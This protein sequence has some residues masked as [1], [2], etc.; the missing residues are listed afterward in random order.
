MIS[1]E[2]IF[3]GIMRKFRE[4]FE[5]MIFELKSLEIHFQSGGFFFF[6]KYLQKNLEEFLKTFSITVVWAT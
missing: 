3:E 2:V 6:G 1:R 5:S 4:F